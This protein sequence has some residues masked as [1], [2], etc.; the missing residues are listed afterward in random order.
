MRNDCP[1]IKTDFFLNSA[2]LIIYKIIDYNFLIK[3][4]ILREIMK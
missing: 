4:I 3:I 2:K 1:I